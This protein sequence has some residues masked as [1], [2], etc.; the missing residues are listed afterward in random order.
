LGL[1]AWK[2]DKDGEIKVT[3]IQSQLDSEKESLLREDIKT[4][5]KSTNTLAWATLIATAIGTIAVVCQAIFAN[6][7]NQLI[8]DQNNIQKGKFIETTILKQNG[9]ID[10]LAVDSIINIVV[11]P[12][13]SET[14]P[15]AGP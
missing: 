12:R 4:T 5:A 2:I 9:F 6:R 3:E 14:A 1:K 7:Q 11:E 10:N 15:K 13:P 8:E